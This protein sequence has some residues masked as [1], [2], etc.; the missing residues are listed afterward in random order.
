MVQRC[1]EGKTFTLLTNWSI[2]VTGV[3]VPLSSW[4]LNLHQESLPPESSTSFLKVSIR[5]SGYHSHALDKLNANKGG[6]ISDAWRLIQLDEMTF[7]VN[8]RNNE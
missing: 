2:S 4:N 8:D 1:D 3:Q 7:A 6:P 5:D